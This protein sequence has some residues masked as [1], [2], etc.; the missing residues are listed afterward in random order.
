MLNS[1]VSE[2]VIESLEEKINQKTDKLE[3]NVLT[4]VYEFLKSTKIDYRALSHLI[5][6]SG[7][8]FDKDKVI[9]GY[10]AIGGHYDAVGNYSASIIPIPLESGQTYTVS[11]LGTAHV[12][13]LSSDD[14]SYICHITGDEVNG[15]NVVTDSD[16]H[17]FSFTVPNSVN[18]CM[19]AS[20][21]TNDIQA[22]ELIICKGT[23][24]GTNN[25]FHVSFRNAPVLNNSREY[26]V[27][28]KNGNGDYTTLTA[29][30]DAAPNR[31]TILVMPGIYDNEIVTAGKTKTLFIIGVDRDK[32]VIKNNDGNYAHTP[33][34]ISSGLLRNLTVLEE[35]N[36][37]PNN[38][39]YAVHADFGTGLNSSLR[40]ENCH[41]QSNVPN[42]GAIGI[43][44]RENMNLTIKN[45]RLV[46]GTS[47]RAL[48]A[49]DGGAGLSQYLR[50]IDCIIES[51][52]EAIRIQGQGQ[53]DLDFS[54]EQ[55][56]IEFIR[57]RIVGTCTFTNW[58]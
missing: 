10:Y 20:A 21:Q 29:A 31:A 25:R 35:A 46:S 28:D 39:S 51:P 33:I 18:C 6:F 4:N 32:C 36:T 8:L 52:D 53:P 56:Y 34:H 54:K 22:N 40:I 3:R 45:C 16:N 57:N 44:L 24:K 23:T 43:G 7:N 30:T 58:Y 14:L 17:T 41:L 1:S 12:D 49:H 42:T 48:Y 11:L 38:G 55:Y 19:L 26:I 5:E 15:W 2:D 47:G 50:V 9:D 37:T 13:I 27:V